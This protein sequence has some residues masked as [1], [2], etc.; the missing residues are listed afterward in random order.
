MI[1]G[2]AASNVCCI[3]SNLYRAYHI[4]RRVEESH[5]VVV[6]IVAGTAFHIYRIVFVG[7]VIIVL[8]AGQFLIETLG[9]FCQK[10]P[11]AELHQDYQALE[12]GIVNVGR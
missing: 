12:V 10:L 1:G 2:I 5:G 7:R 11:V 6:E 3:L 8:L 9:I 4:K